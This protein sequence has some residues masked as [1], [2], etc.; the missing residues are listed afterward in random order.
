MLPRGRGIAALNNLQSP[1][2]CMLWVNQF[3]GCI[4]AEISDLHLCQPHHLSSDDCW[5]AHHCKWAGPCHS[6]LP[7][8]ASTRAGGAALLESPGIATTS[9]AC[10]VTAGDALDS[11]LI[12]VCG[13]GSEVSGCSRTFRGGPSSCRRD[14]QRCRPDDADRAKAKCELPVWEESI[15]K[16]SFSHQVDSKQTDVKMNFPS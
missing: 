2:M 9:V 4:M 8:A 12:G 15:G 7:H 5:P 6:L 10:A 3:T 16:G 1:L 13:H 11:C 14:A